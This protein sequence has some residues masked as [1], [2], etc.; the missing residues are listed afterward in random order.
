MTIQITT[1]ILPGTNSLDTCNGGRLNHSAEGEG[2][3]GNSERGKSET[4]GSSDSG[5][6]YEGST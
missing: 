4:R 2:E 5:K 3:R 1:K 6:A